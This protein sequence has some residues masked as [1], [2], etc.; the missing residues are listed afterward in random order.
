MQV[1]SP[2][3]PPS[4]LNTSPACWAN[5]GLSQCTPNGSM[6]PML[7]LLFPGPQSR[8]Q[9]RRGEKQGGRP[10]PRGPTL[11]QGQAGAGLCSPHPP[12]VPTPTPP[13]SPIHVS[14]GL[15]GWSPHVGQQG[16]S[17]APTPYLVRRPVFRAW[18]T[19]P[20]SSASGLS[21]GSLLFLPKG[22]GNYSSGG[23]TQAGHRPPRS[24]PAAAPGQSGKRLEGLGLSGG[25]WRV[26]GWGGGGAT[27]RPGPGPH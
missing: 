9:G 24:G 1:P 25:R 19:S 7:C 10:P 15:P 27:A 6:G 26:G 14:Q 21:A 18:D 2:L 17:G 16:R 13:P 8:M 22:R 23:L 20:S 12:A 4:D 11:G 3:L 5:M